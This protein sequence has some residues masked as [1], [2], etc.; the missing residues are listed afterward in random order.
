MLLILYLINTRKIYMEEKKEFLH[1]TVFSLYDALDESIENYQILRTELEETDP[2]L[3]ND[4]LQ[5]D[6][7]NYTEYCYL[8]RKINYFGQSAFLYT[9]TLEKI[10]NDFKEKKENIIINNKKNKDN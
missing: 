2:S 10:R 9:E 8:T 1:N 4:Y 7:E 6:M 5:D 3:I